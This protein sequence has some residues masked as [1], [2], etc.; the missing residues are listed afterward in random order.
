MRV[1]NNM[2]LRNTTSNINNNK[3][4]VN[5][6]N[7]QMSSQKKISRPSEDPVVAI[8]ALR[9]RSNLS[10]INQ[11]YEKNIPDAD[12]WL[13]VTETALVNMK[14]ILSDIRTQCTYGASDQLK[15]EDR[16]TILTQLESLRKQIYSEGNSDSAGRTVFTGYRTN[17]KLTFME[18]ESNTEYNIQQKFSYE[19]IGEHRYYDGQVELK[20]AEEMSQKVTTSDTKQYTYDRIRLAYGNIGSLKDKDGNEIAVGNT[21]T[22]SYH[23]TDNTGAAKTGD[24]NV[25]VYETE[26]DWK[27]A[28]KAGNMP[29]DGAAFIKST[30]ELV[31]GNEASETLKQNKASIE[32]NYDKKGFN[33]GEVRPEYYFNCTDITDAKNKITYEK[34]DAKGNEIYQDIDYIIAVNQT[35]TVNTNASDVFNADIGRDVDEMI[36]AVKAAID[37]NDKVDKIKDMMSQAA[38]SGVSAQENLQTWLEA[39]QKEADYANDNLQK[40]YDSYIGNFDEYLSDVN[41]SITTVG[42][43]GDRLELTETRMSNQQLTVK[44]LKSNNEDRELSDIISASGESL[45]TYAVLEKLERAI[46]GKGAERIAFETFIQMRMFKGVLQRAN[47][48]LK[49]MSGG[50]YEFELRTQNV[51]GN[52]SEGLDINMIDNN[53]SRTRRRDVSTLSG[54]ERFMA[55]FALAIGLSDYTLQRGG[56]KQ[57]DMLFVD[58]G[59]SSLDSSTFEMALNVIQGIS[60]GRRMIGLVTHIDGIKQYFKESQI[61]V[62]KGKAGEGSTIEV[63][64]GVHKNM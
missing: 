28:V 41:L 43:K 35:L 58:E 1:T 12:A 19:D 13:N 64:C 45:H 27:K 53:S 16:K 23:Y 20:T 39:A 36:N 5:S 2:M 63:K 50:R 34:Y 55:S 57:S 49:V 60:A 54:G 46:C 6:L 56:N 62:H 9:L 32:L 30:G 37:A 38:Y 14:T 7:N 10:E 44:T 52:A 31:L 33:S 51:R 40:L 17:C 59:F 48:R 21:G 15:A 61:Y 8:R 22:L 26:D 11:Y 29:K 4:S 24:L 3:Y 42:S 47:D 18:D 25:T